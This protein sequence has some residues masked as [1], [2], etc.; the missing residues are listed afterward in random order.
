MKLFSLGLFLVTS[1]GAFAAPF[2]LRLTLNW[3][4]EPEFG[5][6]Y[7]AERIG[8]FQAEKLAVK[9]QPGGAGTPVPQMLAAGQTEFGVLGA[10]EVVTA[11]ARGLDLVSLFAVYQSSP[12]G[13]LVREERGFK[14]LADVFGHEGQL[15]IQRGSAMALWLE[16]KYAPVKVKLVPFTGG[17]AP[18]LKDVN[19]AQQ[20][21]VTSESLLAKRQGAAVRTFLVS[22]SGFD[23]YLAVVAV[24][25]DYLRKNPELVKAM[26]RALNKG[27]VSYLKDPAPANLIMGKLNPTIDAATFAE[28]AKVQIPF[29]ETAATKKSGLGSMTV[30]RWRTLVEQLRAVKIIDKDVSPESCFATL[31]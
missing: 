28:S 1:L 11:R 14:T 5:G 27:W 2:D 16:K 13:I 23:P 26:L 30:E 10:D 29:I 18:L 6:F 4:P 12:H 7:E 8:A 3:K 9:I 19:Y 31:K 22:D 25:G 21:F 20:G 15:A 17:I 24:R